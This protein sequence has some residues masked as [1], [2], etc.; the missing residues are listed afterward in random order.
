MADFNNPIMQHVKGACG[1]TMHTVLFYWG[2]TVV[3]CTQ[4]D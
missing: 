4:D 2:F 3:H 1:E